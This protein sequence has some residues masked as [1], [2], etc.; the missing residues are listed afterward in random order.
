VFL[1]LLTLERSSPT[2]RFLREVNIDLVFEQ[3][4][5]SMTSGNSGTLET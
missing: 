5:L 1:D 4:M 2:P 3:L